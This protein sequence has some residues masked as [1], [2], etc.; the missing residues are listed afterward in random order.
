MTAASHP[1]SPP[2]PERI[3]AIDVGSNSIRLSVAEYDPSSG[4]RII[5]EV[6]DQPRLAMRIAATGNLDQLAMERAVAV[7]KRMKEVADRRQVSRIRAVATS[8]VREA[9]NG[10][11]FVK[12]VKR[13]TGITLEVVTGDVEASLSYR[14]VAHHF[15]LN[16]K[17]ALIA[18]IGFDHSYSFLYSRRPGTPAADLADDTPQE[19]KLARLQE[20]QAALAASA[21]AISQSMVGSRQRVLVDGESKKNAGELAARS[22][23]NRVVDFPGAH[24]LIGRFAEVAIT[25]A[26]SHALR[27]ALADAPCDEPAAPAEC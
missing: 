15:Q 1:L 21:R 27:G 20:L 18:D 5:D 19:L 4:L 14:S 26:R 10:R 13:E 6:K 17:R 9:G 7:I 25:G 2:V 3:A 24:A 16:N 11:E 22:D 23:S 12:R 8:A